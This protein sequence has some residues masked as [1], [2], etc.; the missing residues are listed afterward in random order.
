M[1]YDIVAT[2]GPQSATVQDWAALLEAGATAFRLNTSHLTLPQLEQWLE[3]LAAFPASPPV[4]LDLQ[5]S[6]WRLGEL[7]AQT[8]VAGQAVTLSCAAEAARPGALPVPHADFFQAAAASSGELVLN[9]A[10]VRLA[11]EAQTAG[12][13][14]ARVTQ[15]GEISAHKGI[16]FTASEYR[17]EALG[18]KDRRIVAQ[19]RGVKTIRYA[20]SYVRD[21]AEMGRYRALIGPEAFL[22][23]K[24]E[25]RAALEDVA[26]IAEYSDELW[27]CR[28]DLGAE[29]GSRALA[30]AAHHFAAQVET[31]PRPALL[32]GQVLEHMVQHATPTRSEVCYLHE[33]L[34]RGYC[35]VVLSD[36]TAVGRY[37]I[38]A[39]QAAALFRD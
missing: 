27:L 4:V 31:L 10:K 8:L 23:A 38:E 20:L 7:P 25:R 18:E 21:A 36:E 5:G 29:L 34:L 11:L 24:L 30:E 22:I 13:L 37:P 32:A 6:K 28:G 39:C 19:T 2:L 1:R 9:D 12:S 14:T 26:Q 16:T 3:A 17:R 15:G 35:G 33:A